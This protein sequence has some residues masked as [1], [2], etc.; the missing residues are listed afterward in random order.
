MRHALIATIAVLALADCNKSNVEERNANAANSAVP[1][2][3]AGLPRPGTYESTLTSEIIGGDTPN[4]PETHSST[5]KFSADDFRSGE[6]AAFA[7]AGDQCHDDHLTI[8]HGDIS[9]GMRCDIAEAELLDQPFDV[10]GHYTSDGWDITI[11]A[12]AETRTWR[13][14]ARFRRLGD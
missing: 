4:A 11:D 10:Q 13:R 1:D 3:L 2:D 8:A 12:T 6:W 9:G 7:L 14:T 5:D